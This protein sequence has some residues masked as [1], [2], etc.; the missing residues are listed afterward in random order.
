[1]IQFEPRTKSLVFKAED[2]FAIRELIPKSKTLPH[3]DY[4]MAVQ[5]SMETTRILRNLG[6]DA[7]SPLDTVYSWPGKYTPFAHQRDMTEFLVMHDRCFN[8]SEMGCVDAD[9]EY[10]SP[11]GWRRIAGYTG[12]AVAQYW[13]G[14]GVIDFVNDPQF[15]KLPCAEMIRL[16]TTRGVDQLLSPEHRVLLANGDV[17]SALDVEA[18]YDGSQSTEVRLLRFRTTF[19]VDGTSGVPLTDEQIRVQVAANADGWYAGN[20]VYIRLKRPRKIE[21]MR[22]LLRAAGVGFWERPCKPDGYVKFSFAQLMSKGFGDVWWQAT[23]SQLEIVADEITH[24]DGSFRKAGGRSFSS[25]SK[26]DV[27]FAQYAY[28]AAGSRTTLAHGSRGYVAH[29]SAGDPTIGLYGKQGGRAAQNVTRAP[30]TDGFKYCFMVPSTFLLLRRNGCIF[31]TG[32]TA[33]TNAA[34]WAADYLMSTKQIRRVLVLSPLSTLERVWMQDIF[35][36]LMHRS[37]VVVHGSM[38]QRR[39]ALALDKD[40]YI[41]N[42]D[43]VALKEVRELIV[44]RKDIDLIIVDEG[45]MFR[46]GSTTKWKALRDLLKQ[47]DCGL[48]WLTGTPTPNAPTDAWAQA[49]LVN[50]SRVP[51]FFGSFKRDTMMQVSQ[52]KWAPRPGARDLAFA[53]LQPA[54]RF[55]KKD[56][57]DLPP[58]ITIPQQAR[59]TK[60]QQDAFEEMKDTMV[61][62]VALRDSVEM[63]ISAVNAADKLGK[64][65]QILCGAIKDPK[66]DTYITI[67]HQPRL[68]VL[69]QSIEN[70]DAKVIVI[71]PFKGIIQQLEKEVSK[72]YSVGVL[73]GDVTI[74]K[75]NQIISD[76]KTTEHPHVLLCHPKVM[77]HGLNLTEADTLIFYA[78]IY[79]N[80]EYQQVIERFNRAG[81]TRK[82]TIVR[83][84]AHP[85]EW[86]IYRML[87]HRM[88]TQDALLNLYR[89]VAKGTYDER[90]R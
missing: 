8:L 60:E 70:A 11:T 63:D 77:A 87:D 17:V 84:G 16:K 65:R 32:N 69:M 18:A 85:M 5:H 3:P 64:L 68:D 48:W 49:K 33:K 31:A 22:E 43:G 45:S 86:Q 50:P 51:Q 72:T 75:R 36:T 82:M 2:P 29:A 52:Y 80:D 71:V 24:W 25:R 62:E 61:A 21:R 12:G 15:V 56:C 39:K 55:M 88:Q 23:Q 90:D 53:A 1:M 44:K 74:T 37:A 9:T 40:F 58:V 67:P 83:I 27:D 41:L 79:S 13:P 81:Q 4:N 38:E 20:K 89:S 34:L 46:N 10:L 76:F 73:N 26:A 6:Y 14:S 54:I 30:S 28:S 78:P 7:P 66:T 42:H 35:D 59:L 57:L 19:T 47:L